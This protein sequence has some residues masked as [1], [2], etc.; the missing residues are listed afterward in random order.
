MRRA[1]LTTAFLFALS[2]AVFASDLKLGVK[3]YSDGLYSLAAKTFKENFNELTGKNFKEYY[4]YAYLSFLKSGDYSSLEKLVKLWREKYPD[5][6]RGELLALETLIALHR[7]IPIEEAF[8]KKE[9]LA[10][11]ISGKIAFFKTLSQAELKPEESLFVLSVSAKSTELKGAVK[12]SGFLKRALERAIKEG[13]YALIDFIFDNYG[14]WFKGKE[15][16]LQFVKY[17]ERKKRF[18]D[19]LVEAEKL[20][21]KY[22]CKETRFEL[23][24]AYY[25]NGK[26]D[27]VLELIKSPST[28]REKYLLA[29][30]YFRLGKPKE[31]APLVGLNVEKPS[32]PE[33][34][35]VLLDFY[36][37]RFDLP[38][39][40]KYYP[41]LYPKALIFSFSESL[42]EEEAGLPHDLAYVYWERGYFNRAKEELE[43]AVQ[44]PRD[45]NLTGRSLYLLGKLGSVNTQVGAVVYNQLLANYQNTPYYTESLIPAARVY[46]YS[47]SPGVALKLL[48]YAYS[49]LGEKGEE[50]KELLGRLYQIR[51]DYKKAASFLSE[52]E[53]GEGKTL[54]A[55]S[56][57]QLGEGDKA[58]RVLREL[59]KGE[60]LFPEVNG[61]RLVFLSKELGREKDLRKVKNLPYLPEVMAAVVG[62]DYEKAEK[63]F[64]SVPPREKVVLALFL[65]NRYESKEPKK[66]FEYL[67]RLVDF[68]SDSVI[69]A[70][71]R[72]FLNYLAFKTGNYAP[73]LF[74]DPYFIAYNPEN[75]I[76]STSTLI[77]KA[78]DYASQGQLGKA[79]G[80]LRLA[81]ERTSSPELRKR[82]VRKLV[83]IDLKQKN[84]S[85]ALQDIS[86][87]PE[88]DLKHFLLFK[89]YLAM[90]RLVDAYDEAK[91]VSSAK[92]LPKEE[93]APFLAKL[94]RYY[95]LTG[96]KD[97][98]LELIK[99][100]FKEGG[101][102]KVDYDD[103]VS[104]ALLAQE[105][106]ELSLAEKLI[107]EAMKKAKTK[108]QKAESLF[109][110]ASVEAQAGR[111]DDAIIDYM[112]IAYDFKGVE[113]WSSTALYRAAQLFEEKGDYRQA[114]KLYRKVAKLK[115]GTKEGEVA[116][117]KVKSLLKKLKEE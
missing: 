91:R 102:E 83:E 105:K 25:L 75:E 110:K 63:L 9:L 67:T 10:L 100:L 8:P 26:Y 97:K 11:P 12:D 16:G 92:S 2:S 24:R 47:G 28:D 56:L 55:Y 15:E 104:L 42:P 64:S 96:N 6:S 114:L 84:Y 88:G 38:L 78:E 106:G 61:G 69:S 29:W 41:E 13:D 112:K 99:E 93:R 49:R 76:T 34:L 70:Y 17:L 43:K 109:W 79:Y 77:S 101:L 46:L 95:K 65:V 85:R 31:I 20:Y 7:G 27:K 103:L 45:R 14:R 68:S 37:C 48:S 60:P 58:Y 39:L 30:T 52:V 81:F 89:T 32:L 111:T 86:L 40:K 116:A 80:L 22:P 36:S 1:L 53:K 115:R 74:S 21:K 50:V 44:S 108:E 5:F 62:K 35:R 71:A 54:L 82:I 57:Y 94:A 73:V 33:K 4:R 3:L 117:E 98:A 72:S 51:G 59:F 66:A 90:G 23:A 18:A 107:G 87:I 19:A 113:P